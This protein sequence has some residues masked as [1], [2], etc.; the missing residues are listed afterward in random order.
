MMSQPFSLEASSEQNQAHSRSIPFRSY[1]NDYVDASG[2][3]RDNEH[4]A[5][6]HIFQNG[7]GDKKL[8]LSLAFGFAIYILLLTTSSRM[9]KMFT[10]TSSASAWMDIEYYHFHH[11]HHEYRCIQKDLEDL[12]SQM[13]G[14]V[15]FPSDKGYKKAAEVWNEAIRVIVHRP[16]LAV[17]EATNAQDVSLAVRW[18]AQFQD[19]YQYH[20]SAPLFAVKAGGHSY[21]GYSSSAGGII[22]SVALMND[23]SLDDVHEDGDPNKVTTVLTVGPGVTVGDVLDRVLLEHNYCGVLGSASTVAMGGWI[24][25]GGVGF[26]SRKYGFGIDNVL[27]MELVVANGSIVKASISENEDLFW[28]LRGAGQNNFG[29]VTEIKYKLFPAQ[30]EVLVVTGHLPHHLAARFLTSLG[31]MESTLP[32]LLFVEINSDPS[33]LVV[34]LSW[35]GSDE[36]ALLEGRAFIAELLQSLLDDENLAS[37]FQFQRISW[38][39]G[40]LE[41]TEEFQGLMVQYWNGFLLP[42]GN[43]EKNWNKIVEAMWELVQQTDYIVVDIE[44][45]GGAMSKVDPDATPLYWRNAVYNVGY[46]LA[47]PVDV[48]DAQSI[49]EHQVHK[50]NKIW[51]EVSVYLYGS[52]PNYASASLAEDDYGKILYGKNIERLQ[53]IKM[54]YDPTDLFKFPQSVPLPSKAKH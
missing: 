30:D 49:F 45:W 39:E 52:F 27:E 5:Q 8:I 46:A 44:L 24:L 18:L 34:T 3:V 37:A 41:E 12:A 32:D 21:A 48:K 15:L 13:T 25:G 33:G 14:T 4:V 7:T 19:D 9:N 42:D 23:L 36:Q 22:L 20:G 53:K 29:V 31:D 51:D 54:K 35:Y 28:A 6:D 2:D 11:H 26:L 17:I 50:F 40:A 38:T 43:T 1:Q 16:P 47:V 10:S